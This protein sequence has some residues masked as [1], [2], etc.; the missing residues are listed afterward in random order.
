[1][2]GPVGI[3]DLA[4][5]EFLFKE[6]LRLVRLIEYVQQTYSFASG[7]KV[8]C[9]SVV[10]PVMTLVTLPSWAPFAGRTAPP[11]AGS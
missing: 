2:T 7:L 5:G 10:S 6:P 1:V 8:P 9:G 3:A 11:G 4:F